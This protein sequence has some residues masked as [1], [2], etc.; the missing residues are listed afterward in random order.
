MTDNHVIRLRTSDLLEEESELVISI[1][2][3]LRS[4]SFESCIMMT[5]RARAAWLS[6]LDSES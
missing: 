1:H 5:T 6:E 2:L 4:H 3:A